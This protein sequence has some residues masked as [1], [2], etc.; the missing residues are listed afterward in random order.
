MFRVIHESRM[1]FPLSFEKELPNRS[2]K[3][4]PS[5]P[6]PTCQTQLTAEL[7]E[8]KLSGAFQD[9]T[10]TG[11]GIMFLKTFLICCKLD[12]DVFR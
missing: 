2:L 11:Q 9:N 8:L 3:G 1:S 5:P 12:W 6:S 7:S 4:L 10:L